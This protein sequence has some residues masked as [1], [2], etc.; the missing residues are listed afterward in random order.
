MDEKRKLD[1]IIGDAT[2][3]FSHDSHHPRIIGAELLEPDETTVYS[4]V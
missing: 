3:P 2:L 4:V 1:A